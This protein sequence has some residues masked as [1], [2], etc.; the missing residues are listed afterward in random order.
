MQA[1]KD[2]V[3]MIATGIHGCSA[4]YYLLRDSLIFFCT[5][6]TLDL[7]SESFI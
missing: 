5:V 6:L 2:S 1:E 3:D 7:V 4:A